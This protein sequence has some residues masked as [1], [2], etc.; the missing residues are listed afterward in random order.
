MSLDVYL[1]DS[2]SNKVYFANITHNLSKMAEEAGIYECLWN[3]KKIRVTHAKQL[4]PF[5]TAGVT[6]LA[7]EKAHFEQFNAPNNWGKWENFLPWCARYLQ[8][9]KD[10]PEALVRVRR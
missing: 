4:I 7:T 5:L 2:D 1:L 10:H 6:R 3:P 8:A 9:C